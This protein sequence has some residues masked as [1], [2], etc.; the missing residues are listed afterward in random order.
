MF[1]PKWP[2][3]L[4]MTP[5]LQNLFRS[6]R[7][8]VASAIVGTGSTASPHTQICPPVQE[9][10]PTDRRLKEVR[11]EFDAALAD[12][13]SD[14][15]LQLRRR[16]AFARSLQDLWYL[17]TRVFGLVAV[18][19]DQPEAERRLRRLNRHFPTRSPLSGFAPLES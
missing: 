12:I 5:A 15:S 18:A 14:E 9:L 7:R 3:T 6:L 13:A 11:L 10:A 17:R 1:R 8:P 16:I 19:R 4:D 2:K